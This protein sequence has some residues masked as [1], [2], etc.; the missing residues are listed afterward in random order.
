MAGAPSS[1]A[2]QVLA[3]E[4]FDR[5][6]DEAEDDDAD[7]AEQCVSGVVVLDQRVEE[8]ADQ[9]DGRQERGGL[10]ARDSQLAADRPQVAPA[11]GC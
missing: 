5:E 1:T 10:P 9:L 2:I 8:N 11:A 7:G 6:D 3:G 4:R